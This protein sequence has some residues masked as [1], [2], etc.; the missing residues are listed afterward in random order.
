MQQADIHTTQTDADERIIQSVTELFFRFGVKS[1]TMDDVA[2]HL[3]ISKKTL[4]KHFIDKNEMVFKCCNYDLEKRKAEFDTISKHAE[5]AVQELLLMMANME[6]MLG[7]MNPSL[8]FDVRKYYPQ[9]WERYVDFKEN[10]MF[11]KIMDNLQRGMASGIYREDLDTKVLARLRLEE[12]EMGFNPELFPHVRF[13]VKNV[14]L[15]LFDHFLHG[16]T[17]PKGQ[18]LIQRYKQPTDAQ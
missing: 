1:I 15:A 5:D 2:K 9:A 14:Q 4:Y 3:S 6:R 13:N 7:S 17:T 8:L 11:S 16:I 12:V 10:H 18:K